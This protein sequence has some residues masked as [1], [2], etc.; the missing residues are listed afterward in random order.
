MSHK[1]LFEACVETAEFAVAAEEGGAGRIEL[2]VDLD[3]GGLTPPQNMID[4]TRKLLNIPVHVLI[5]PR[6]GDFFYSEEELELMKRDIDSA[7]TSGANGIVVGILTAHRTVD[8]DRMRTL[9]GLARPMSVTFHRAFDEVKDP[10]G[11]LD[12]IISLG[13]DRLLTSG[14][15]KAAEEGIPLLKDIVDAAKGRIVVMPGG[16]IN[17]KNAREIA[18]RTGATELHASLRGIDSQTSTAYSQ[19]V[20]RFVNLL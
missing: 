2:C 7:G 16:G 9:V 15:R 1:I 17:E 13:I 18:D 12:D 8:V 19:R 14:L 10:R 11:A 3:I 5:R 20:R 6:G 4:E